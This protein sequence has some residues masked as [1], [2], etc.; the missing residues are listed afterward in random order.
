LSG[1]ITEVDVVK[2]ELLAQSWSGS[3]V[4]PVNSS[5]RSEIESDG[6]LACPAGLETPWLVT[7]DPMTYCQDGYADDDTLYSADV[8]RLSILLKPY[9]ATRQPGLAAVFVYSVRPEVRPQF[10]HFV[11]EI[12]DS[13]RASLVSC[14]V[15]HRGGNRN[16]GGLLCSEFA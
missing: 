7:F 2:H 9:I 15:T 8:E 4:V 12:A 3:R 10:W 14:W 11:E 5:W 13:V 6:T 16:L 1:G